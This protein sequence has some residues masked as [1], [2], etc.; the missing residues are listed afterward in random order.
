M[1]LKNNC[2][3]SVVFIFTL[4]FIGGFAGLSDASNQCK[5]KVMDIVIRTCS[6]MGM[7]NKRDLE[8]PTIESYSDKF[9]HRLRR[10]QVEGLAVDPL[11]G[12]VEVPPN[13]ESADVLDEHVSNTPSQP[14]FIGLLHQESNIGAEMSL[15]LDINEAS[16]LYEQ[17]SGR[18]PRHLKNDEIQKMFFRL[19][20]KCCQHDTDSCSESSKIVKCV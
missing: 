11:L 4:W 16:D 15:E 9:V 19:A 10:R 7:R 6:G 5:N 17:L 14:K 8:R 2:P 1:F 20:A 18:L 13:P 12:H 3:N